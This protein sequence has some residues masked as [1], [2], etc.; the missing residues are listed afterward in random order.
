M[1]SA[2]PDHG[3]RIDSVRGALSWCHVVSSELGVALIDAGFISDAR[4]LLSRIRKEGHDP[5]D[6]RSLVITHAHYDH[7]GGAADIL[8]AVDCPVIAHPDALGELREAQGTVSPAVRPLW[9]AY[10]A[11]AK[12]VMSKT[13]VRGLAAALSVEDGES[14][15]PYGLPGIAVHLHGHSAGDLGVL[16]ED[17]TVF[18]GDIAQ[19]IRLPTLKP[20]PPAMALDLDA[21]FSSWERLLELG[22]TRFMPAHGLPFDA[23]ALRERLYNHSTRPEPMS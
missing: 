14:L 19:G 2:S 1:R 9:G 11:T 21:V 18:V 3:I 5:G 17:G 12:A 16:L 6:L 10:V 23:S 15:R 13:P 7:F 20:Q 4:L 8:D 22:A